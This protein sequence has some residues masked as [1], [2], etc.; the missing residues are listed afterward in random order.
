MRGLEELTDE[1]IGVI[2]ILNAKKLRKKRKTLSFKQIKYALEENGF[3][4]DSKKKLRK[5]LRD[6]IGRGYMRGF[7]GDEGII[8]YGLTRLISPG[9][10]AQSELLGKPHIR[11][12][13]KVA[14]RILPE[15]IVRKG[16]YERLNDFVGGFIEDYDKRHN[17]KRPIGAILI[18]F[19]IGFW[20]YQNISISGAVISNATSKMFDFALVTSFASLII[21]GI[22][23]FKSFKKK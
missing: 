2:E 23:L 11:N 19:G 3:E 4:I 21:G 18:L 5:E 13:S 14:E 7:E 17:I 12:I 20:I 6:L 9:Y 15:R 16:L 8:T 10:R 22:L 1:Q